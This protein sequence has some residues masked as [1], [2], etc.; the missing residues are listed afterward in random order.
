VFRPS[1]TNEAWRKY[2]GIYFHLTGSVPVIFRQDG[3]FV[4]LLDHPAIL[5]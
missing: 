1:G 3:S 2:Q 4:F 5:I